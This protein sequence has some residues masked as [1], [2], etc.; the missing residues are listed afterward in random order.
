MFASRI[1]NGRTSV[2]NEPELGV[3]EEGT[4]CGTNM[5]CL[6]RK[7][8]NITSL[9]TIPCPMGAGGK[10]CSGN[11]VSRVI[12]LSITLFSVDVYL[13][14]NLRVMLIN[15]QTK[16]VYTFIVK[17][18]ITEFVFAYLSMVTNQNWLTAYF[19]LYFDFHKSKS[20]T[21]YNVIYNFRMFEAYHSII[22]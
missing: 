14:N 20:N 22:I 3:V 17:I 15:Q 1:V 18:I 6:N 10:V 4:K 19:R 11:G 2:I 5:I 12:M 8:Q 13:F 9:E 21:L 7:C 16:N